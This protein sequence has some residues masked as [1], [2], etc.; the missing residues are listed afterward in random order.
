MTT[1]GLESGAG[2]GTHCYASLLISGSLALGRF[3]KFDKF[4]R[5]NTAELRTCGAETRSRP[6]M[7]LGDYWR[8]YSAFFPLAVCFF[9]F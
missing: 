5:F 3:D 9:L 4:L 1:F 7:G 2:E 6:I 8:R